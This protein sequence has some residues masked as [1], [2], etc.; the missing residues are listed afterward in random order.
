MSGGQS[1]LA[2]L[3]PGK[4]HNWCAFINFQFPKFYLGNAPMEQMFVLFI[5]YKAVAPMEHKIHSAPIWRKQLF[6]IKYYCWRKGVGRAMCMAIL[7]P[8]EVTNYLPL[9]S[10]AF[11]QMLVS[12]SQNKKINLSVQAAVVSPANSRSQRN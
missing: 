8:C 9:L 2:I 6:K 3:M 11:F 5:Y 1:V 4:I 10:V 12:L 7:V